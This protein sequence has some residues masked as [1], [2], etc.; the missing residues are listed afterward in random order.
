[1]DRRQFCFAASI[2]IARY[3]AQPRKKAS[4]GYKFRG[5]LCVILF[6]PVLKLVAKGIC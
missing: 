2:L 3:R 5:E 1:M 6:G 4:G